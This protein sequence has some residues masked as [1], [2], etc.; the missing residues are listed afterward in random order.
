MKRIILLTILLLTNLI[1]ADLEFGKGLFNDQLY[2]EAIK[3]FQKEI[4]KSPTSDRAQES[5]FYIGKSYV[6]RKQYVQAENSF[7]KLTEGFPNNTFRDEALYNLIDVQFLQEKYEE[8]LLNCEEMLIKYPLSEFT[9]RSL[10]T[11]LQALYEMQYYERAIEKGQRFLKDYKNSRHLPDVILILA[12]TYFASNITDQG[13]MLLKRLFDEYANHNAT[14][15]AVGLEAEIVEK[16]SGK[17]AAADLLNQRLNQEVPR[18]FEEPLRLKLAEYY[19][20]LQNYIRAYQ[21]LDKLINKF[22]NSA[23]L[24][25]YLILFAETQLQ[26]NRA[27]QVADEHASYNKVFRESPRKAE[28]LLL[29]AEAHLMLNNLEKAEELIETAK[30]VNASE[31]NMYRSEKLRARLL[32]K[33]GQLYAAISIF[34]NLLKSSKAQQN[35][36]LMQLGDIYF[37][38]LTD[39]ARAERYYS[40]IITSYATT[41]IMNEA[42]FKAALCQENMDEYK[43]SLDLL[44]QVNLEMLDDA[45]FKQSIEAKIAYLRKFKLQDYESAFKNLLLSVF[46]FSDKGDRRNLR[47]DVVHILYHNLNDYELALEVLAADNS[48]EALYTKA[49]LLVKLAEKHQAESRNNL[50]QRDLANLQDLMMLLNKQ[51]HESWLLELA[52]KRALIEEQK[53]TETL[54]DQLNEY[55][56]RFPDAESVN[57]FRFELYNYYQ[58][59]GDS[60]RAATFAAI[61]QN[62]GTIPAEGFY[63]AKITLADDYFDKELYDQALR[64][65]RLADQYIDMKKPQTYFRY[66]VTLNE[67]G[68]TAEARDKLVF[69]INNGG[70][71][72]GYED[73]VSYLCDILRSFGEYEKT[74]KFMKR[75]PAEYQDDNYWQKLAQDYLVSGDVENGK[76][77]LMR[78]VNKDYETLARLGQLQYETGEFEMA[79]YTFSQLT[80]RNK[81]DLKNYEILGRIAFLQEDYLE[82][83]KKYKVIVDKLDKDF[84][85]YPGFR[86]IARENI[87]ALYRIENRP[88]AERLTSTFKKILSDQDL[89]EIELNSGIYYIKTDKKKSLKI[90]SSLIKDKKVDNSTRIKAYFWRGVVR[91]EQNDLKEAEED[92]GT[93][94]NSIDREMSNQAHLKLGTIKFSGEKYE[95]ALEHYFQVI[96]NDENGD[97]A[98]DAARNFAFVC[99]T[100]EEWQKAIAAY[101][102]IL[103]RWGDQKLEGETIFDIAYCHYRDRKYKN[104]V[105]MFARSTTLLESEEMKAEA[106]YWIG[107]SYFS[108]EEFQQAV[109]EFLKVGYN[110]PQFTQWA[111]SAELKAGEAYLEMNNR[112]KAKQIYE[113]IIDKYGRNSQWGIEAQ[114]RLA[115]L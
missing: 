53:V 104:A 16:T 50:V 39:Y 49:K 2:E 62:N 14:W 57:E 92:F 33:K 25:D 79:K 86:Q 15:R 26:I 21:E 103:E 7:K 27:Q 32:I 113:R 109:S 60:P 98:F 99:K 28:Y 46:E 20:H 88:K 10:S 31:D 114:K 18:F 112:S 23:D 12:K 52:I 93:V 44:L 3:E 64:N 19:M 71:F 77:A 30:S 87:I 5:I 48:Y 82:A 70:T 81:N 105:A 106:Q 51:H 59:Q 115:N 89:N 96:Q 65:Y 66:A 37:E 72:P 76:Y 40:R 4:A 85:N 83:A 8:V 111:A 63:A 84:S 95:E 61:L 97:L 43:K 69:L 29:N 75:V 9:E 47:S 110:Y 67:T 54:A 22:N 38:K 108:M 36:I 80:E 45:D 42:L 107:E 56:R 102:I 91:L 13:K 94:A 1:W 11:Y 100:I 17:A 58:Q 24:D 34:Q 74:I 90:F 41:D 55:I 101:Q 6:Q 73:V 78:I 35:E 68:N